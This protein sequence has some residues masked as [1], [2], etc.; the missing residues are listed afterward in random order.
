MTRFLTIKDPQL[1]NLKDSVDSSAAENLYVEL[2]QCINETQTIICA[3]EQ[4]IKERISS[5]ILMI[6]SLTNFVEYDEVEPGV[7]PIKSISRTVA[8]DKLALDSEY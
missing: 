7:G 6:S 3:S 5:R 8:I 4:E 2:R 1:V